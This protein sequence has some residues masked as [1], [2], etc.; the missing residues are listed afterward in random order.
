MN[1]GA[2]IFLILIFLVIVAVIG[3]FIATQGKIGSNSELVIEM[4]TTCGGASDTDECLI[5]FVLERND[6]TICDEYAVA[7]INECKQVAE[8]EGRDSASCKEG[9]VFYRTETLS[10]KEIHTSECLLQLAKTNRDS[11]ICTVISPTYFKDRCYGVVAIETKDTSL[12]E[13]LRQEDRYIKKG[14]GWCIT[15]IAKKTEDATICNDMPGSIIL[16]ELCWIELAV[17]QKDPTVCDVIIDSDALRTLCNV[18]ATGALGDVSL[19]ETIEDNPPFNSHRGNCYIEA[20]RATGNDALCEM[21]DGDSFRIHCYAGVA[22]ILNDASYCEQLA[23]RPPATIYQCY[24]KV[25]EELKDRTICNEIEDVLSK[26][27]CFDSVREE[28]MWF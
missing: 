11:S 8:N 1:K 28:I 2:I 7:V 25:A 24:T 3:I 10:Q 12:C 20:V 27:Q 9:G 17:I 5:N 19:C 21:V 22:I 23:D 15:E 18:R 26:D 4:T 13:N 6:Q 16:K 14:R